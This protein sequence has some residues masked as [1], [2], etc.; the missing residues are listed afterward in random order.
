MLSGIG[1]RRVIE[2]ADVPCVHELPG[3]G[4]NLK[5]HL[6][7]G[8]LFDAPG[9]GVSSLEVGISAGPDALREP[10]G[11]LPVDPVDEVNLTG[12]MAALRDESQHRLEEWM[13]TG[14]S[15]VSSSLYDAVAFCSTGLGDYHSHD[16]QIAFFGSGFGPNSEAIFRIDMEEYFDDPAD[17]LAPDKERIIALANPVLPRSKGEIV[18]TDANPAS[19]PDVRM[20]YFNDP[21]DLKVTVAVLPRTLEIIENWQGDPKPGA[22]H[23]PPFLANKHGYTPGLPPATHCLRIWRCTIQPLSITFAAPVGSGM[24]SIRI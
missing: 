19:P 20:N 12:E 9:F 2:A 5:D 4:K 6:Q 17:G 3:V 10:D 1:P 13:E 14:C 8:L 16:A 7:C 22:L 24:S 23:V 21:H 15:L 11:L 18:L